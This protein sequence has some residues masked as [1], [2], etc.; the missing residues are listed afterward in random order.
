MWDEKLRNGDSPKP[1]LLPYLH[2]EIKLEGLS[3]AQLY[4]TP[5]EYLRDEDIDL[6]EV[7]G[8]DDALIEAPPEIENGPMDERR[9]WYQKARAERRMVRCV[10]AREV[11]ARRQEMRRNAAKGAA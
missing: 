2:D 8:F 7:L 6:Y 1:G 9:A 4:A 5:V 10:Q 3:A 11:I